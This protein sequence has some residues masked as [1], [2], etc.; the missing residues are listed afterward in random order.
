MDIIEKIKN[1]VELSEIVADLRKLDVDCLRENQLP[2]LVSQLI[3]YAKDELYGSLLMLC[4]PPALQ[5]EI[6]LFGNKAIPGIDRTAYLKATPFQVIRKITTN[7]PNDAYA[8]LLI[9]NY[10]IN[11]FAKKHWEVY[12]LQCKEP[13][14]PARSFLLKSEENG[15]FSNDE[16]TRLAL[17]NP[18][19]VDFIP[20]ARIT[21]N[22]A[23]SLLISG[24]ADS[25]W[26][27]YDFKLLNK[28][29]WREL[30]LHTN[31]SELP[32]ACVPFVE[33]KDGNGFTS[34][35]LI[36][37][38]SSC[39]A[40]INMLDPDKVPFNVAYQLYLTGKGDL[41]WKRFP[42]ATLD[43]SE[44]R[45]ILTNPQVRIPDMFIEIA[46]SGR[47]QAKELCSL[48]EK[49]DKLLPFLISADVP[50]DCII[51]LLLKVPA[52]HIWEYWHFSKLNSEQW[53]RL[54]VGLKDG[55]IIK[56][57]AMSALNLCKSIT[58]DQATKILKKNTAYCPYLPSQSISPE[59]AVEVLAQGKGHCLW[60]S[61]DF[62]RLSDEQW[63]K[64]LSETSGELPL[65]AKTYLSEKGSSI[66]NDKLNITLARR[67]ELIQY[68]DVS[69]IAP[70]LA[71]SL[72][73][74]DPTDGLWNRYD[75]SRF[76]RDQL[77]Y[78]IKS[79]ERT[80]NW[81]P[82]IVGCFAKAGNPLEFGDLLEIASVSPIQ[83]IELVSMDWL[84]SID[85]AQFEKLL[86]MC[87]RKTEAKQSIAN[88]LR[89]S[90]G[91]WKLL[92]R[93]KL[94]IVLKHVEMARGIIPWKDWDFRDVAELAKFD[95]SFESGIK[96]PYLYFV[97]KHW[98]SLLGMAILTIAAVVVL[99]TQHL[100]LA[101][102]EEDRQ[103]WNSIVAHV[104]ELDRKEAYR[105]LM[106]FVSGIVPDDIVIIKSDI[107]YS[108]AINNLKKWDDH[109]KLLSSIMSRLEG[110]S[111]GG[112]KESDKD[113]VWAV[114]TELENSGVSIS[115]VS[116]KY[117]ALKESFEKFIADIK[118]KTAIREFGRK[119]DEIE[120]EM[121]SYKEQSQVKN[122]A[123]ILKEAYEY[124]ELSERV[125]ALTQKLINLAEELKKA[126]A[127]RDVASVSNAVD[128]VRRC[129]S[130]KG[131]YG[132]IGRIKRDIDAITEMDGFE[133]Y[134]KNNSGVID[135]LRKTTHLLDELM[136]E[137]SRQ[138]QSA[139]ELCS[140]YKS[141]FLTVEAGAA[142]SNVLV[143]CNNVINQAR[144][145]GNLV[146]AID[147]SSDVK[148]RIEKLI[149]KD[150]LCWKYVDKLNAA[151]EFN[152]YSASLAPLT[153][154]F[155]DRVELASLKTFTSLTSEDVSKTYKA[156]TRS[157]WG[158]HDER[159]TYHFVGCVELTPDN[160][161]SA[162]V[163]ID[164]NKITSNAELYTL[165]KRGTSLSAKLII[166]QVG[167]GKY[168]KV[169]GVDYQQYNGAPLFVKSDQ[170][171][172]RRR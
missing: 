77:R 164:N 28:D 102:Q 152:R 85:D 119:L 22:T 168:Y 66:D 53:V 36:N 133:L 148:Q 10:P 81:T 43:K 24:R 78:L 144:N 114:I 150:E 134:D 131:A 86:L 149:E 61:Y 87:L 49:N 4:L 30:F 39:H 97:W 76:S 135:G 82:S 29:H 32:T 75:F 92:Q 155:G 21:P 54:I 67:P 56:P 98:V 57:R 121:S 20:P 45:K 11:S 18:A 55:T 103:R 7:N 12:F 162:R 2:L 154:E 113:K 171:L 72:L 51:D 112:W 52:E 60:N 3:D 35:E 141:R 8:K 163:S 48:A 139:G 124:Q 99:R 128:R 138:Q 126:N 132:Q 105:D 96:H 69:L 26:E 147:S 74:K 117:K 153:T 108:N 130:T 161:S 122:A 142:C 46:K 41:L 94:K 63:L 120:N 62:T 9:E 23:I 19:L 167:K 91:Q 136:G 42:F 59:M 40:L 95:A 58:E 5:A 73:R 13:I 118:H 50:I 34:D 15:G 172:G 116:S 6:A 169:D 90:D 84:V 151:R 65:V 64:L 38:A 156:A 70:K 127:A 159:Y 125:K 89:A 68:V 31:P 93:D 165:F 88:K 160:P 110:Y 104:N 158:W 143:A 111:S 137:I 157:T 37:M 166:R 129:L 115:S 101:R 14:A 146:D 145:K 47:F 71:E 100:S 27:N 25:L 106:Q 17:R 170:F 109:E 33:N 107:L 83:I 44:W 140:N 80:G 79:T 123:N 1:R 16:M